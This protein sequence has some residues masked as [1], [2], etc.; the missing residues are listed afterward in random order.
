M[1]SKLL[2]ASALILFAQCGEG[3][4]DEVDKACK[5]SQMLQRT[6][7]SKTQ[8]APEEEP[9][10][11]TNVLEAGAEVAKAEV[12]HAMKTSSEILELCKQICKKPTEHQWRFCTLHC[13]SGFVGGAPKSLFVSYWDSGDCG[14]HGDDWHADWC[15]WSDVRSKCK[16]GTPHSSPYC[17]DNKMEVESM[18]VPEGQP[19][20]FNLEAEHNCKLAYKVQFKCGASATEAK[21]LTIGAYDKCAEKS[22][23]TCCIKPMQKLKCNRNAGNEGIRVNSNGHNYHGN[24][25]DR[26]FD[27][28][29][30]DPKSA[31]FDVVHKGDKVCVSRTDATG[32]KMHLL[33][34]CMPQ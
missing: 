28:Y 4:T 24:N 31:T 27:T 16:K 1:T 22:G 6:K 3:S 10:H 11:V 30:G 32:W 14:R 20:H 33:L 23:G 21:V 8:A 26:L 18:D 19:W 15:G 29:R 25:E 2:L 17:S 7:A 13:P 12:D 9:S 5:A 34:A